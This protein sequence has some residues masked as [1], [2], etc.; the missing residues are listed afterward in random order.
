[1]EARMAGGGTRTKLEELLDEKRQEVAS[2][3]P[4]RDTGRIRQLEW[5][6]RYLEGMLRETV[7]AR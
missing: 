7:S 3:S 6:I 5:E 1:M 2:L 4:Q